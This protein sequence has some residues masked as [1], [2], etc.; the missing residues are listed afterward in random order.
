LRG[1]YARAGSGSENGGRR[2]GKTGNIISSQ[3]HEDGQFQ[4]VEDT[5][6]IILRNS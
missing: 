6:R 2:E 1:V 5:L 4:T 3:E